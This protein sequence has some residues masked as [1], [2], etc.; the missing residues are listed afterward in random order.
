MKRLNVGLTEMEKMNTRQRIQILEKFLGHKI[1][2][3]LFGGI[4]KTRGIA[5]CG[6]FRVRHQDQCAYSN[7]KVKRIDE[8]TTEFKIYDF[9][10]EEWI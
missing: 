5:D 9:D 10:K 4:V 8:N 2:G 3:I 6:E 1:D 7:I